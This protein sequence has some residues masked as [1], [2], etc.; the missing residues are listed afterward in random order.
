MTRNTLRNRGISRWPHNIRR[1]TFAPDALTQ[2]TE[3]KIPGMVDLKNREIANRPL[4]KNR[5]R[6]ADDT[7]AVFGSQATAEP[8]E[9][10]DFQ[11][12]EEGWKEGGRKED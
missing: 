3:Y 6:V 12:R 5:K 2:R 9:I 4:C 1:I 10:G 11:R 7:E 8:L